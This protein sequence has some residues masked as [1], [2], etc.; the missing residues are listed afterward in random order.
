MKKALADLLEFVTSGRRYDVQNPHTIPE[1]KAAIEALK[2][3]ENKWVVTATLT[4]TNFNRPQSFVV[5]AATAQDA[6]EVVKH[7][8]ND[9]RTYTGGSLDGVPREQYDYEMK[10]YVAPPVGR[11][12]GGP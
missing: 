5:E 6:K 2:A 1:V 9:L 12:V 8:L 7:R 4:P 11:I 10:P 3:S